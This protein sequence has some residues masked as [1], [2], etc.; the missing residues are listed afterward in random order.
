MLNA[1]Q[2]INY[3]QMKPLPDEGGLS[4]IITLGTDILGRE[5]VQVVV[6]AD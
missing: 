3:F 2:I 6:P 1:E 4:E 5:K